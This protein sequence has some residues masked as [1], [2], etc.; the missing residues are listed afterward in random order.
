MFPLD[1]HYE[2]VSRQ[3]LL[4]KLNHANVREVPE[5]S[6][7]RLVPK[8]GTSD[9]II[10]NGKLAMEIA[11]GQKFRE[12]KRGS[13]VKS[14]RSNPIFF[15]KEKGKKENGYGNHLARESSLQGCRMSHFLVRISTVIPLLDSR[16]EIR[17]NSI[18]VSLEA[19][20]CE[21][22]SELEDHFEIF[23]DMPG[24]NLRILTSAKTEDETLLSWSG[25]LQTE[26][27]KKKSDV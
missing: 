21:F 2:D 25:L 11:C 26:E 3:D 1:F 24:F 27:S 7:I 14:F 5:L 6:E 18:Q 19:E 10:K 8:V 15:N 4:L 17:G 9:F 20:F 12:R 13:I 23:E 22:A 16:V